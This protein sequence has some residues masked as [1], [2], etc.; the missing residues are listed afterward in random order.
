MSVSRSFYFAVAAALLACGPCL[1]AQEA[2]L[3]G[4]SNVYHLEL[5]SDPQ[6]KYGKFAA[7]KGTADARGQDLSV[8]DLSVLQP[9]QVTL[10]SADKNTDLRLE[11]S[12][13]ELGN[14]AARSG[15]TMG[16]GSV[17]FK[18]RTQGDLQIKV[19]SPAGP[20]PYRLFVWVGGKVNPPVP[21]VFIPMST[22]IKRHPGSAGGGG[23]GGLVLW[24]IAGA[25][26][27]ICCFLAVLALKRRRA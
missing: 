24:V 6:L 13:I 9:V 27:V 2:S 19:R 1:A 8:G 11:L 10:L 4:S 12:K 25:L 22:Y 3:P 26:I 7:V 14:N 16:A 23:F 18:F 5:K 21:S 17:T 15:S 20:R